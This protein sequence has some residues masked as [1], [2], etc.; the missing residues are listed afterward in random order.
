V[1]SGHSEAVG[2]LRGVEVLCVKSLILNN[3]VILKDMII[4]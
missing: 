2:I 1:G 3:Y 4:I